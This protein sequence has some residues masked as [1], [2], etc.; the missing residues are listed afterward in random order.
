MSSLSLKPGSL[1]T[2]WIMTILA[3]FHWPWF[4]PLSVLMA[5]PFVGTVPAQP[6]GIINVYLPEG[7]Q[8]VFPRISLAIFGM[9]EAQN[10]IL[11]SFRK[12]PWLNSTSVVTVRWEP[13]H[14]LACAKE[15]RTIQRTWTLQGRAKRHSYKQVSHCWG[16]K[17]WRSGK[18]VFM[19]LFGAFLQLHRCHEEA[20]QPSVTYVNERKH[21]QN[22]GKSSCPSLEV[23]L[24][25]HLGSPRQ[26]WSL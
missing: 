26:P 4:L 24:P 10:N 18:T 1:R 7:S 9:N 8:N 14:F 23:Q 5:F 17:R 20:R 22:P 16:E 15:I 19:S 2:Q 6:R 21:L 25:S 12:S 3:L 11:V 13:D